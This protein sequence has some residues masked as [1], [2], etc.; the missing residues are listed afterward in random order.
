VVV[1]K[2]CG[3]RGRGAHDNVSIW[4]CSV[5]CCCRAH[6]LLGLWGISAAMLRFKSSKMVMQLMIS[7]YWMMEQ[8]AL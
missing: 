4:T 1:G 7:G 5:L 8:D 3:R 2:H 6:D